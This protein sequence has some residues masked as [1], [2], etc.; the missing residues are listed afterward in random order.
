MS[1]DVDARVM[2]ASLEHKLF[3]VPAAAVTIGRFVV[4]ERLGQGAMGV[5]YAVYD[6]KL[7]RRV[8]LKLL[9][10]DASPQ[11][12]M[13]LQREAQAMARLSH[14]NVVPVFEVGEHEHE[15]FIVLEY[16]RGQTLRQWADAGRRTAQAVVEK[17]VQAGRGLAAAH[18]EGIVHRDFKPDNAI[19]GTGG[20][21]RVL[22]FGLARRDTEVSAPSLADTLASGH[23]NLL[24][25]PLTQTGLV[26]GTPAYM[27]PEQFAGRPA[28][29]RTDQFAFCVS[30]WEALGGSRPFAGTTVHQLL[31]SVGSGRLSVPERPIPARIRRVLERGLQERPEDRWASMG[32]LLDALERSVGG[33]RSRWIAGV[34]LVAV[35]GAAAWGLAFAGPSEDPCVDGA[36]R[37]ASAW[38]DARRDKVR[39]AIEGVPVP[40]ALATAADVDETL[41]AYAAQWL[42]G[43]R[44][45]C[46][47]TRVHGSQSQSVMAQRERCLDDRRRGL[48]ALA[49][50]LEGADAKTVENA[51]RSAAQLPAIDRCADL[52]YVT[53]AEPAPDD[54]ELA[55]RREVELDA[56]ARAQALRSAG[57]YDEALRTAQDSLQRARDLGDAPLLL[58]ALNELAYAQLARGDYDAALAAA[59]EA[60]EVSDSGARQPAASN[61]MALSQILYRKGR[62]AEALAHA[63]RALAIMT[64]RG[65]ADADLGIVHLRIGEALQAL[66]KLDDVGPEYDQA[67]ALVVAGLGEEHVHVATV[68]EHIGTL[69]EAKGEYEAALQRAER[70]LAIKTGALGQDHPEVATA[71]VGVGIKLGRLRRDDESET[72]YRRALEIQLRIHGK[73]RA[74]VATTYNNLALSFEHRGRYPEAIEQY[75]EALAIWK[76]ALGAEHPNVALAHNNIGGVYQAL[77]DFASALAEHERAL[78]I[79]LKVLGE[80]HPDLGGTHAS[81]GAALTGVGRYDEALEHLQQALAAEVA[82]LGKTHPYVASD[83]NAIAD[84]LSALGR[85]E[86]ALAEQREALAVWEELGPERDNAAWAQLGMGFVTGAMGD[87]E[88][89][90]PHLHEASKI[91]GANLREGHPDLARPAAAIVRCAMQLDRRDEAEAALARLRDLAAR[92]D[93]PPVV[94]ALLAFGEGMYAR[95]DAAV[96]SAREQLASL[97]QRPFVAMADA[98]LEQRS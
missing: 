44:D 73:E 5:V 52:D 36:A 26:V 85:H 63:R 95:D 28:D 39:A 23:D 56:L 48:A 71:L 62:S 16:V 37:L 2:Q 24:E 68:H 13:R 51:T 15:L 4:L 34:A 47:A 46:E 11:L 22:D 72:L 79:E 49:G 42:D 54:P 35:T 7:D 97:S 55:A 82:A 1:E 96:A 57:R 77:G 8:A 17:Y 90:L 21:V 14:P 59:L 98:W 78:A 69:L 61:L 76:S 45:A 20:R 9:K 53:A 84:C 3:G 40:Y 83:H 74:E 6:D 27:A 86:E 66:G 12:R 89:A 50:V 31:E 10:G 75:R 87:C 93:Q 64:T 70:A 65:A 92:D 38:N 43:W 67:L 29:H 33:K 25:T 58:R 30:L 91:F 88:G 41:H 19:V 32:A 18:A 94:S 60:F 81:L 80:G